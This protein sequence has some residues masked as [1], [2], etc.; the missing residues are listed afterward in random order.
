M[1]DDLMSL[2]PN[3]NDNNRILLKGTL[4]VWQPRKDSQILV[5]ARINT[6]KTDRGQLLHALFVAVLNENVFMPVSSSKHS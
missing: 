5:L 4:T 6:L 3:G 2:S 1:L